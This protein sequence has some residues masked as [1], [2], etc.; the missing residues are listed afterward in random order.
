MTQFDRIINLRILLA[1]PPPSLDYRGTLDISNLRMSF[2]V[3]KS[4]SYST[5]TCQLSVWNLGS[6]SRNALNYYGNQIRI[7]AGYRDEAGAQLI[8]IGN[9]TQVSHLFEQPEIISVFEIEDGERTVNNTLISISF[10]AGITVRSVIQAIADRLGLEIQEFASTPNFTY[11]YGFKFT[12]LA[13]DG[14]NKACEKLGLVWSVQNG[15]LV[16]L[17]QNEGGS[18]PPVDININTGMVGIPARDTSRR[19]KLY[20]VSYKDGWMVRT[21]LKPELIPGDIIRLRS[22][23]VGIDGLFYILTIRHQGDNFSNDF[24]SLLQVV[25]V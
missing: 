8:F 20:G 21:L 16:I 25:A 19:D 2:N 17:R 9:N 10:G 1:S 23:K 13:K 7:F 3:L 5:N 22:E 4:L 15:T 6:S 11:E 14:L 18:K 24:T 12:G